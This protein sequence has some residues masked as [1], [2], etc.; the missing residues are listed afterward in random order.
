M[1]LPLVEI[2]HLQILRGTFTFS[3]YLTQPGLGPQAANEDMRERAFWEQGELEAPDVHH[4]PLPHSF[5]PPQPV[6]LMSLCTLPAYW[7]VPREDSGL[8]GGF[9]WSYLW[10]N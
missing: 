9:P 4:G 10:Q 5:L 8:A 3:A 6:S 7:V 1:L 2:T